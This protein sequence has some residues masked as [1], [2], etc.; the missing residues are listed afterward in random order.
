MAELATIFACVAAFLIIS[1][2]FLLMFNR[3]RYGLAMRKNGCLLPPR[4]PH[5]DPILGYDLFKLSAQSI[6]DGVSFPFEQNLFDN[7]GRTFE[8]NS[9]GHKKIYTMDPQNIQTVLGRQINRFVVGELRE[10]LLKPFMEQSVFTADGSVWAHSRAV[11]TPIFQ[12][13]QVTDLA[14]FAAHVERL[15]SLIPK[16][17]RTIDLQPL[18]KHLV[19]PR[20]DQALMDPDLI[21]SISS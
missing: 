20:L 18:F 1:Y 19:S 13:A 10:D 16:D 3:L 7:Y 9:W 12:R 4:Y 15:I 2:G 6:V 8:A 21:W 17:G 5:V 14:P 11:I